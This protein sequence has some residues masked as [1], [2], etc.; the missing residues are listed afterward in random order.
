M[1]ETTEQTDSHQADSQTVEVTRRIAAPLIHVWEILVSPQG[2]Q[3][4]LGSGASFGNKGDSW[5]TDDGHQGVV[6]S[7]HP[8]EQLRVTW[9]ENADAPRSV[10]EIDLA[11]AAQQTELVLRH[12]RVR[13]DDVEADRA[14]WERSLDAFEALI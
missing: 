11:D 9:H 10:V 14:Q 7:F 2:A 1:S 13:G 6:R 12:D 3:A 5:H 4:L 8:M